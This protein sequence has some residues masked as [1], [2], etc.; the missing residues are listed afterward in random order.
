MPECRAIATTGQKA[1]EVLSELTGTEAPGMG[2]HVDCAPLTLGEGRQ[3]LPLTIWRMPSTS[4][5]YPLPLEK[6]AAYYRELFQS[7]GIKMK[8]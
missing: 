1:A 3:T 8:D 7:V 2:H 4:R 5:A 6:K